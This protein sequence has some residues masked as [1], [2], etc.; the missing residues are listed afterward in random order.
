MATRIKEW[1]IPYKGWTGIEITANHIINVLLRDEN[2]LIQVTDNDELYVDLQLVDWIQ[3]DDDFPVWVTTGKIL[4]ED[5]WPQSGIILNWKTTSGDYNRWIYANDTHLYFDPWTWVRQRIM[6]ATEIYELLEEIHVQLVYNWKLTIKENWVIKWEFY[7]NQQGDTVVELSGSWVAWNTQTFFLSSAQDLV[8]A[9]AWYD[10]YAAGNEALFSYT[11]GIWNDVFV[12]SKIDSTTNKLTFKSTRRW[13]RNRPALGYSELVWRNL[14]LTVDPLTDQVTDISMSDVVW[15]DWFI[16]I[17]WY[18]N[19]FM[20]TNDSDPATKKYVDDQ[21]AGIQPW[22]TYTAGYW[23]NIDA[24]NEISNTLA[25]DPANQWTTGQVIKKT[26]N[27]YE[28]DD[29]NDTTYTAWAG[30]NIDWNNEI[31]NT[32]VLTVNNNNPDQNGNI[33]VTEFDPDNAGSTGQVLKKTANGYEWANESWW[34]STYYAGTWISIDSSNYISNDWVLTVNGNAPD[35][36]GNINVSWTNYTAWNWINITSNDEIQNS[37]PFDPDNSWST[38]QVLKKTSNGYQWANESGWQSYS[39][40]SGIN[41]TS[42]NEIENTKPFDP[43]AWWSAGQVLTKTA[44]GYE[45][46]NIAIPSGENNVKFW[47]IDS[48]N[49]TSAV[50]AEI[51]AW[52]TASPNNW[53]ILNDESTNRRDVYIYDHTTTVWQNVSV[54]FFWVNR[55][56]EKHTDSS[57]YDYTVWFQ[58]RLTIGTN[59]STYSTTVDENPDPYTHTN[60]LSVTTSSG[61]SAANAFMPTEDYQ[62]ATKKYVDTVATGWVPW[63]ITNVTTGTTSTVAHIWAWSATEL[64]NITKQADTLYFSFAV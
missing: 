40:G 54:I 47:N 1:V 48:A 49:M 22:V 18:S 24:N 45:W 53:A 35:Q 46:A 50:E 63:V 26:A 55:N 56:T 9:Q 21:I 32:W 61:Y 37:K 42:N 30:I 23:I 39:A 57:N 28:W 60:Y 13:I 20:P 25:F 44:N 19:A 38:G 14:D 34:W 4:E 8:N 16:T 31:S 43:A 10:W 27:W 51:M 59:G 36:N 64:W 17:Q 33:N 62:P 41:I 15:A 29:D 7:A 2:N 6:T 52:V 3:P 5:W 58:R 12:L 11:N